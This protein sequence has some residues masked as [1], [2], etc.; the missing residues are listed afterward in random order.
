MRPPPLLTAHYSLRT[1]H[2]SLTH[3]SLLTTHYSLLTTHYSLLTTHYSL[4]TTRYSLLTTRYSLLTTHCLLL[5][6][7]Y[8]LLA[9]HLRYS[10]LTTRC[11]LLTTLSSL[12]A[13]PSTRHHVNK[14][15]VT[16][17]QEFQLV[18]PAVSMSQVFEEPSELQQHVLQKYLIPLIAAA[19]RLLHHLLLPV[20]MF[21]LMS[22]WRDGFRSFRKHSRRGGR[23][24]C[25]P[26]PM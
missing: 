21:E 17:A 20:S 11:S 8:S 3:Y 1:T 7:L 13:A 16:V 12:L 2:Y 14:S 6:T 22:D 25:P 9:A 15:R 10:L 23:G 19:S 24:E 4:F 5:I 26:S 18:F